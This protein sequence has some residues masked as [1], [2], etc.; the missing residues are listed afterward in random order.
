M[1]SESLRSS[2][3]IFNYIIILVKIQKNYCKHES[4]SQSVKSDCEPMDC[5]QPGSSVHGILQARILE[6]IAISYSRG[7]SQPRDGPGSPAL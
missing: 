4:V 1:F 7:S 6:W 3:Y 2:I 5:S